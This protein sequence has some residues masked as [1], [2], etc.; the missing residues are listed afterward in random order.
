ML[1][2]ANFQC[3]RVNDITKHYL[4]IGKMTDW[5]RRARTRVVMFKDGNL[6]RGSVFRVVVG[7]SAGKAEQVGI[8]R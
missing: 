1:S 5:K 6:G 2:P 7:L 3:T 8:G 4:A